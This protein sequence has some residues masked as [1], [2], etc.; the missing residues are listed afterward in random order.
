M[1]GTFIAAIG[2]FLIVVVLWDVFETIVLPRRVTRRFRLTRLFYRSVWQPWRAI[3]SAVKNN[4]RRETLLS[5]FGPLSLLALLVIWAVSLVFAFAMIHWAIRSRIVSPLGSDGFLT[6]LYFSGTTFFTLGLG[7]I[8]PFGLAARTMT[9]IEASMGI[10]LLA[11][12]IGYFPVL[13]QAF[14]RREVNI[15]MLDARAGTPPTAVELLRRH[16]EAGSLESLQQLLRD[17]EGWAAD[18]MESH[19]SYPVLCLFS[20][21]KTIRP[22]SPRLARCPTP[23]A[24]ELSELTA[25]PSGRAKLPFK[26][27]RPPLLVFPQT[28]NTYPFS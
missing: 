20:R 7:D 25:C 13:Y 22:G 17:W 18:L 15:S 14:S 27:A 1:M 24:W 9:V 11:L 5:I 8:M 6:D 4:K 2:V 26:M 12:V 3:S 21:N 23:S 10:G 28:L 16:Q 19:L